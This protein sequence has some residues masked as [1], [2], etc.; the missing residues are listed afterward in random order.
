MFWLPVPAQPER[1][2]PRFSF[3][4]GLTMLKTLFWWK[5]QTWPL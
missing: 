5:K 1:C 4:Q 2:R 3:P